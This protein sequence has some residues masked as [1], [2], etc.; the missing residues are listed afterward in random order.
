MTDSA[1]PF[2][3][4]FIMDGN[5]RWAQ[6]R[7]LP[8]NAGHTAGAKT[9]EKVL[10]SCLRSGIR[11]A[12][13]Y[14]FSTENWSRPKS[15]VD[16][17]MTLFD[18]YIE[19]IKTRLKNGEEEKYRNIRLRFIGDLSVFSEKR[20][21][22]MR[23]VEAITEDHDPGLIVNIAINYGG[24]NEVVA[25]VNRFISENPGKAVTEKD[26]SDRL[27]TY[28]CPDPDLII[29]TAGEMRISNFLLW[30]SAYSEYY[31]TPVFWPDFTDEELRKA[32]DAF[33]KRTRKYGNLAK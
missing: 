2:H 19:D 11:I 5:G 18:R 12:T 29:R 7:N 30:Q 28:G 33:A 25:A 8:R 16:A 20:Q 13:F 3:V 14:A 6:S 31:S 24:R 1:V 9:L 21:A 26:I 32:L 27:Y 15:E 23:E 4:G 10:D 17:L 22:N